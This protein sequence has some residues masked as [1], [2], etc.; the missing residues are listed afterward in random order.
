MERSA[1]SASAPS[2]HWP[3]TC[4]CATAPISP[5]HLQA[6]MCCLLSAS[7]G[8]LAGDGGLAVRGWRVEQHGAGQGPARGG[9]GACCMQG[10]PV[11]HCCRRSEWSCDSTSPTACKQATGM[12]SCLSWKGRVTPGQAQ[13]RCTKVDTAVPDCRRR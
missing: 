8:T 9:L 12:H 1:S 4:I 5:P 10:L 11:K 3:P 7:A 6:A 13:I 2:R